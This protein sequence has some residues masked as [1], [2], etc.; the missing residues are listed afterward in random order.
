MESQK[1]RWD[2]YPHKLHEE[3][4]RVQ[5]S[6][7]SSLRSVCMC[8]RS[9]MCCVSVSHNTDCGSDTHTSHVSHVTRTSEARTRTCNG[10]QLRTCLCATGCG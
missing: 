3:W 4:L 8:V 2:H 10:T 9:G 5:S 7:T 1:L 6:W